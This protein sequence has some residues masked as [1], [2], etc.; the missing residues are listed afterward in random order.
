MRTIAVLAALERSRDRYGRGEAKKKIAWLRL[1]D[2][3]RLRTAAAVMRLHEALCY[4]RAYPDDAAVLALVE[5]MLGR[6]HRRTDLHD[7]RAAL[8]NSGIAGTAMYYPFFWPTAR[9]LAQRASGQ[10][11]LDRED[12]VAGENIAALLPAIVTAPEANALRELQPA[13]YA[14]L[15][16]LRP[17]RSSDACYLLDRIAAMPGDDATREVFH[18]RIN[19]SYVLEPGRDAPNRSAARFQRAPAAFMAAPPRRDRP[20]LRN[21]IRRAPLDARQLAP[22]D[23]ARIIDLARAAMVSRERDLDAFAYGDRRDVRIVDDGNGLAFAIN[24]VMPERRTLLPAIFGGLMLR[25]G[26]PIGYVQLDVIGRSCALSFNTFP[27]FRG[28]EAAY[29]LAR[30]LATTRHL[31]GCESFTIEPYQLG[32]DNAEGLQSGAWWFYYKQGFRPRAAGALAIV[33]GEL[34]RMRARP[35]V[36]SSEATLERLAQWH[37]YFEL[38]PARPAPLP[39]FGALGLQA[40][41]AL[42]RRGGSSEC[43]EMLLRLTGLRSFAGFRPDERAAWVRWSPLMIG[44]PGLERWS[45]ADRRA[46]AQ[47][48]RSKAARGESD[49]VKR[50]AAHPRLA[51]TLLG[52]RSAGR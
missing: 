47:V 48:I 31:F 46:L 6:F 5:R 22:R 30:L 2:R 39:T 16:A 45:I 20:D 21:E 10:L 33:R 29:T 34:A 15:D 35:G 18:D 51:R 52:D 41:R 43:A 26:V 1:L 8:V 44:I 37:L 27:T 11:K 40:A 3:S 9:W 7:H 25:N 24:G 4:L 42:E 19:P 13:G 12:T 36:R 23:G 49:F 17:R 32:R 14:G 28:G 38:D 50:F